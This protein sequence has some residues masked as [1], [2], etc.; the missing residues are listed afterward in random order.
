MSDTDITPDTEEELPPIE[1]GE[2][3]PEEKTEEELAW[4]RRATR[5]GWRPKSEWRGDPAKWK[6]ARE[7]VE[8]GENNQPILIERMRALEQKYD[9]QGKQLNETKAK[10]DESK[11]ILASLYKW[12][13]RADERAYERAVADLE[14]KK[15]AAVS[16]ANTDAYD[17]A[18]RE[19]DSLQR[20]RSEVLPEE[21]PRPTPPTSAAP[22]A[23]PTPPANEGR[24][25]VIEQWVAQNSSWWNDQNDPEPRETAIALYGQLSTTRPAWSTE[26]KLEE[27][28]KRIKKMYPDKFGNPRRSAPPAVSEPSGGRGERRSKEFGYADLPKDAQKECDRFVNSIPGF[29]R[30]AY[31]KEYVRNYGDGR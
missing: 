5:M 18:Q 4:E 12:A 26:G 19:L 6:P 3:D 24:D 30:E 27:V 23:S 17:I 13:Q 16:E 8:H 10:L 22:P 11:E 14:A 2:P 29:T 9:N 7:F 20:G 28:L 31:V 15:R 21:P 25:P 1:D